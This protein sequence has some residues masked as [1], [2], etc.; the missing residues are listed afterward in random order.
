MNRKV[1]RLLIA[2]VIGIAVVAV[3]GV[4][5]YNYGAS[6]Q[7]GP[8]IGPMRGYRMPMAGYGWG[9]GFG[10]L[11]W[12]LLIGIL[13]FLLISW[14]ISGPVRPASPPVP[15]SQTGEGL[16][17]LRQLSDMHSRGELTD[18]EFAAAKRKLLGL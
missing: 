17:G 9:F 11:L 8:F 5:A 10:G 14:A 4:L 16:D 1:A 3:V 18:E 2:L 15:P 13:V 7:S 12:L 6:N